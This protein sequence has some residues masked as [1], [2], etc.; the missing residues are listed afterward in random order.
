MLQCYCCGRPLDKSFTLV[1]M[2]DNT[3]RVFVLANEHVERV[4]DAKTEIK[5]RTCN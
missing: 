2:S 3:D 4:D 5:V 1:S